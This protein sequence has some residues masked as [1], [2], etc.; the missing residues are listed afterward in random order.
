MASRRLGKE[1]TGQIIELVFGMEE[2]ESLG[3]IIE[4]MVP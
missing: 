4:R 3:P 1:R 2:L